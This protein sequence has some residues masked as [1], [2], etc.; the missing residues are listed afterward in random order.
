MAT[1]RPQSSFFLR[2]EHSLQVFFKGIE[3]VF[4]QDELMRIIDA[5]QRV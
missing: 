2:V 5:N 3:R 4:Y 1:E